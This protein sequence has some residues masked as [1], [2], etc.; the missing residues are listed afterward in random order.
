MASRPT[1]HREFSVKSTRVAVA[2]VV[3]SVVTVVA[4][5]A[6][7]VAA[8]AGT[9][10]DAGSGTGTAAGPT[11]GASTHWI[12]LITG[13]VAELSVTGDGRRSARLVN[14]GNYYFGDFGKEVTL[15]PVAA[16]PMLA[17]GRLDE[18]LFNLTELV[19]QGYDDAHTSAIPLLLKAPAAT[20]SAPRAPQA[21]TVRHTLASV[22][23][24]AVA[25]EK[26][27]AGEFWNG[28]KG[29][30]LRGG[31]VGKVWLD[32]RTRATLDWSAKQIGAP[33]AW[34]SGYDG[35][36]VKVAVLDSGYDVNHPD[37][38][39][40]VAVSQSFI[41]GEAVQDRL[42]HGT[43]A[44]SIVAGLGVAS[45]GKRK[46]VAPG[47]QLLIGKVLDDSG[48]GFDSGVIAG[49]EWAVQQGAKVVNMSL[50]GSP[51]DGTDPVSEAVDRLS[52]SSGA[53]F[54]IAAG[55]SGVE[56]SIAA[57]GAAARALTVG[58]VD[59]DDRLAP[60]SSRGPRLGDGAM[61]P[62]VTAPGVGIAAARAAGTDGGQDLSEFYT[63]M[64]G[65]SMAT[66]H[67]A[68]AA[69]ILAQRHPDWTGEQLKAALA[70]TAVPST[71]ATVPQQGLGRIDIPRSLD[72]KILTDQATLQFGD[73]SWTGKAPTPVSR[74]IAYRNNSRSSVTLD[75]KVDVKSPANV[76]PALVVSPSRLTIAPGGTASATVTLD[77]AKTQPA[78]YSGE[79]V[80][81]AGSS[82]YRTGLGFAAGGRLNRLTV[83]ALDR[84]G[85]PAV[86]TGE[87]VSGS[88]VWNLDTGEVNAFVFDETGSTTL[89]VPAGRYSVMAYV[90][91]VDEAGELNSVIMLGDP[92]AV[93]TGDRTFVFD[94][95]KANKVT[96]RTPQRAD[97][98][99]FGLAWHRTAGARAA[100]QG[101][102]F[103][104]EVAGDVY[105]QNFRKVANGTFQ[106][107]QRWDL[108][109]P[110]L[111]ADVTGPG[112]FRLPTPFRGSIRTTF[113]GNEKLP[114]HDGGD[115]TPAELEGAKGKLAL[116]RWRSQELTGSQVQ[117]AK[118]AGARVVFLYNEQPGHW[119]E[120]AERDV[121]VYLLRAA[122]GRA[123]LDLL[124][125]R[126]VTLQLTGIRDSA[127][128]YDLAVAPSVVNGPLIYDFARMR[129]AVVTTNF[130]END[131]WF[132]HNDGRT[133]YLPG[134]MTG[135][136][137]TRQVFEPVK[138]TDYLATDI[139]GAEW[140]ETTS[141]G[142]W[143]ESG[144]EYSV[145]RSYRP[146]EKALREWWS[147]ISRPALPAA[148]GAEDQG[149]PVAR[150]EDAFRMAI[151]QHVSGD[152]VTYGWSDDGDR[153]SLKLSSNG[154]E[155]GSA[156]WSVAQFP[157]PTKSAWYDLTLDVERGPS[158]WAKTS[159]KTHTVWHFVSG[160]T[161]SR[162]VLPLLQ[163]DYRLAGTTLQL[164]PGYQAGARG[165]GRFR[166]TAELS[167]DGGKTWQSLALK[168][169]GRLTTRIPD[170][171]GD[172]S[173]RV[174][175]KDVVGNSI[176][177]TI[178]KPWPAM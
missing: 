143:N 84:A 97:V 172:V 65:T 106:V 162:A 173:L 72:P 155:L 176:T 151:P 11:A 159:V 14:G 116:I 34:S 139:R 61:K 136:S 30:S 48:L 87:S 62:E 35:R 98:A 152:G 164:K 18:R 55:N 126:E 75:L 149:W 51:S 2:V 82:S 92:D 93:V 52:A 165:P 122:E 83:K 16:Y 137:S 85:K 178:E 44:A 39:K 153:T 141:A 49:M 119:E 175:A 24:T 70:S 36:G 112:G 68:G 127:Y 160:T 142:E 42:G 150:F 111:T 28:V 146:N 53:L 29:N 118:D 78:K 177:Q 31:G 88:Q 38:Q 46:G 73:L 5:L 101:W 115:G 109:Q 45:D 117:A 59:R 12:T 123:L 23:A 60:F 50:G 67:V 7:A 4:L 168:G 10:S 32:G 166:T 22:G 66:P 80:A 170:V 33:T 140:E 144:Y 20:S 107:I 138:R 19:S 174:T 99:T 8:Q 154:K 27:Q 64:S 76:R 1:G 121:P 89:E 63:S 145:G 104:G 134:L 17:A 90:L 105:V 125:Q 110:W 132:A 129:P 25:V 131:A 171:K 157:V 40:Q 133:A 47:A 26:K 81:R 96:V 130:L 128:R 21:A 13:D 100:V 124:K 74:K 163:M 147:P 103:Q 95:R 56:E 167:T 102:Q 58:A 86:P 77:L 41:A 120:A 135:L 113:V 158:S 43:H 161:K 148:V 114:L 91:G 9:P 69:A 54:V 3:S 108:A 79:L 6:S 156:S 94:A 71:G 37:L 15:V 169:V 57:P